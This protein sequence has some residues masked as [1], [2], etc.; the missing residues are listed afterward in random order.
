MKVLARLRFGVLFVA[1]AVLVMLM[2]AK[3]THTPA[4]IALW[5]DPSSQPGSVSQAH[6][7]SNPAAVYCTDLGYDYHVIG[8]GA[9]GQTDTCSLP[10][11]QACS[12]WD[13]LEGKC[14]Q[15]YSYCARQ[16]L[17]ERTAVDGKNAF[18]PEYALCVDAQGK[19]A[20]VVTTL[21]GLAS[22]LNRCGASNDLAGTSANNPSST[23]PA[24]AASGSPLVLSDT[25][26]T[27][28]DWRDAIYNGVE[29]DW[30]SPVKNQGNCGSCWAFAA[31]GQTEA[32][33]NLASGNPTLDEDLAEEYL[34]SGCSNAGS[35][36]GGWHATALHYIQNQG[37]PD[38]ACLPYISDSCSCYGTGSCTN[39]AYDNGSG[40][41][42][43]TCSQR[44]SDYGSRV[45]KIDFYGQIG[46]ISN[47][48][49]TQQALM[50]QALVKYGP[51][52]VAFS[53]VGDGGFNPTSRVYNCLSSGSLNHAV[54]IVGYND[55]GGY[56]IVKNSW[57][58]GWNE[59]GFFKMGYGQCQIESYVFYAH[60]NS[61][62]EMKKHFFLPMVGR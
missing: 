50:K 9:G 2:A 38:E 57:G 56:W 10:N 23:L 7:I 44:C 31:V 59:N 43:A 15:A 16:G 54:V 41:T 58:S 12:A 14:G 42:N 24:Q 33:L 8:D 11:G 1:A 61:T 40:C 30:T 25:P 29:G 5:V 28:W 47:P 22:K 52:S 62:I 21:F 53:W 3:S 51:L 45:L 48:P 18:S 6:M 36:C 13:F 60:A 19:D 20:G 34:V 46:N 4:A 35:C 37:I 39:C 49:A 17:G 32:E 55:A 26:P 27:S